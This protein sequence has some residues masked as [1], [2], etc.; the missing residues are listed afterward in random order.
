[1]K[2][3]NIVYVILMILGV[4]LFIP[5]MTVFSE[6]VYI[7]PIIITVSIFLFFGGLIKLRRANKQFKDFVMIVFESIFLIK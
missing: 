1:M 5:V 3:K 2:N 4:L 7:A 6:T